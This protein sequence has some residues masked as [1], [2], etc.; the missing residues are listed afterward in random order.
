MD[1]RVEIGTGLRPTEIKELIYAFND[2]AEE[3]VKT[4]RD[5]LEAAV[6][7]NFANRAKS[8]F[9]AIMSHDLRTPLN[10]IIVSSDAMR[11]KAN[12][13]VISRRAA[14]SCWD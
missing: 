1:A 2:M 10:A 12:I 14:M 7:A 4:N 9:L 8:E 13:W 5:L 11:G 6:Q 3:I